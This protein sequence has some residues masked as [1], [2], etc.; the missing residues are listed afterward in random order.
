MDWTA[1]MD[2]VE[3]L[4]DTEEQLGKIDARFQG[5]AGGLSAQQRAWSPPGGGWGIGQ[6]LAHLATTN[7]SYLERMAAAIDKG[8]E[9]GGT[10][11]RP[12]WRPSFFGRLLIR[13]LD[14]A[15]TRP[16]FT[17]RTWRP[18]DTAPADALER[19]L[20]TQ[21]QLVDLARAARE[22]DLMAAR[23]SSPANRLIRLNLGDPFRIFVVHGWRHLG[24]VERILAR[25]DFPAD[26]EDSLVD[27][28]ARR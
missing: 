25:P 11:Q 24:Q 14:P 13:S 7:E 20:A 6:V 9:S 21:L 3:L 8:R 28:K 4:R 10:G 27:Q 26:A 18:D 16:V 5:L 19:F 1:A 12:R 17:P 2:Q 22:V 15:S 23:L